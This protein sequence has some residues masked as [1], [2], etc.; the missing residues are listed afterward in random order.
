MVVKR[1]KTCA[2]ASY[3]DDKK[4]SSHLEWMLLE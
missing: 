1:W 3:V 2:V 4:L